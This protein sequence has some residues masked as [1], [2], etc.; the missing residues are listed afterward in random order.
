MEIL[1]RDMVPRD[2]LL[3]VLFLIMI[4]WPTSWIR[5]SFVLILCLI[6][7]KLKNTDVEWKGYQV[8]AWERRA[9]SLFTIILAISK[10]I[11]WSVFCSIVIGIIRYA[12]V[13]H[14]AP[15]APPSLPI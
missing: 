15:S 12:I 1:Y 3:L 6:E 8:K 7:M 4:A 14:N 2:R 10:L 9:V 5:I 11:W 13:R